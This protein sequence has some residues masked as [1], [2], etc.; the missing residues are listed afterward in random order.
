MFR[1]VLNVS[2]DQ[3][4]GK[5]AAPFGPNGELL[6]VAT[7]KPRLSPLGTEA[8]YILTLYLKSLMKRGLTIVGT[9]HL[10]Q[11]RPSVCVMPSFCV[12]HSFAFVFKPLVIVIGVKG[13]EGWCAVSSV[14]VRHGVTAVWSRVHVVPRL[15]S[16]GDSENQKKLLLSRLPVREVPK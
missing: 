7:E 14:N 5:D 6:G 4:E 3:E 8:V 16:L 15:W 9:E 13:G 1:I 2:T 12:C 11:R 10:D